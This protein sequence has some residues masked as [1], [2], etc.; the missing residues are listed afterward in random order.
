MVREAQRCSK[1]YG[2]MIGGVPTHVCSSE[3]TMGR[4][5]LMAPYIPLVF[6]HIQH[7][8]ELLL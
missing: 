2:K 3:R 6:I 5:L 1:A 8:P 4:S 7:K